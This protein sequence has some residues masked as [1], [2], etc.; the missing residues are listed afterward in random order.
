MATSSNDFM[1]FDFGGSVRDLASGQLVKPT[2]HNY[3]FDARFPEFSVTFPAQQMERAPDSWFH[4]STHPLLPERVLYQY[5]AHPETFPVEK[6]QYMGTL[7]VTIGKMMHEFVQMCLTDAGIMPAEMQVCTMC[8]PP[9]KGRKGCQEAGFSDEVLGERGH[10]DGLL[11][12][13]PLGPHV[14]EDKRFP[15]FE[16]KT[17]HDNFGKLSSIEDL[18]LTTFIKKWPVYYAQQQRYQRMSGRRL[19][20]VLMMETMYPWTMREFHIPF[21]HAL[22]A[23]IDAKY[24]RVRQAVA[25]QTPPVCCGLKGCSVARLCGLR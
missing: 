18:D 16:F 14:P 24:R 12:L 21:D 1:D 17:S 4:P 2:L 9:K 5:L 22:N 6:K 10:V 25:D 11:D 7:S 15:I 23:D 3:L 20:V 13:T 8:P 19:S